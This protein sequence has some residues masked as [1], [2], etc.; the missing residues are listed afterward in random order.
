MLSIEKCSPPENTFLHNYLI[1]GNYVDCYVTTIDKQIAFPE[2]VFA[3][4]TTWLFKIEAFI[5]KHTVKKPSSDAE[6][7]KLASA[8]IDHFAAWTVEARSENELLMCD[9][10]ARTHSWFMI[11]QVEDKTKLYFGSAVVPKSRGEG[12]GLIF[13]LLLGF[14][15]IYSVLLL[16]FAKRGVDKT[17]D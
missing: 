16:Y 11:H 3:F 17:M 8:E 14:H 6:A 2:F 13:T 15:Q 7:K 5:L 10:L 1:N 9:M 12:L 4:Y